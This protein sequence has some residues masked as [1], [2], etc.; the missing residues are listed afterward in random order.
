MTSKK[1][2]KRTKR[3]VNYTKKLPQDG[4]HRQ[5]ALSLLQTE[6]FFKPI[7]HSRRSALGFFY[8]NQLVDMI[9]RQ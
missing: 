5:K 3:T 4:H 8:P 1:P 7:S 6:V 2:E 9:Q